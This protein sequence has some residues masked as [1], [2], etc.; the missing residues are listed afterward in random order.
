VAASLLVAAVLAA[1]VPVAGH[2]PLAEAV[3]KQIRHGI[4]IVSGGICTSEE[5]RAAGLQ[6]CTLSERGGGEDNGVTFAVLQAGTRFDWVLAERSDGSVLVTHTKNTDAGAG[7]AIGALGLTLNASL[8]SGFHE[9]FVWEFPDVAA[10][11]GFLRASSSPEHAAERYPPTY[12]YAS[13][14]GGVKGEG[15]GASLDEGLAIGRRTGKGLETTFVRARIDDPGP[16][17]DLPE[18]ARWDDI[19]VEYSRD[20]SGPR[21]VAFHLRGPGSRAK[22]AV[23]V[24]GRLD[25]RD[26]A[27][28][29][30]ADALL[31]LRAPWP[32]AVVAGL[33]SA[34]ARTMSAGTVE[35]ELLSIEEHES[36]IDLSLPLVKAL[37]VRHLKHSRRVELL[38][39]MAWTQGRAR[40]REDCPAS[41]SL[42]KVA[43]P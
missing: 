34:V 8:S 43:R 2:P 33:R 1:A 17:S 9:G 3:A 39:A 38:A 42:A 18:K 19:T 30:A 14:A 41:E 37:G 36:G 40:A 11:H 28:A 4:C 7:A 13:L 22:T 25:L 21:E 10:A 5:A 20:D 16:F 15:P 23:R 24:T 27:N 29:A 32:P 31:R 35:A 6:P 26:P 12:R